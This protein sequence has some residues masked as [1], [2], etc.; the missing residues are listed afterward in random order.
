MAKQAP[1]GGIVELP[2]G[3]RVQQPLLFT[4]PRPGRGERDPL[5]PPP[6][7][8]FPGE[9]TPESSLAL[10]VSWFQEEMERRQYAAHTQTNYRKGMRQLL[11]FLSP[12]R[13]LREISVND[14]ERFAAWVGRQRRAAKTRELW[15]TAVRTFFGALTDAAVLN[16]NPA[17]GV[18][19][20]KAQSAPPRTLFAG[21]V[22]ALRRAASQALTQD[23]TMDTLPALLL[24]LILDAGL[25]LGEVERLG[26]DD[27][28]LSDPLRP[29][30]RIRYEDRRHRAKRRR[31]V[32]PPELT[33]L[34]QSYLEH[35]PPLA[36][37]TALLSCSRR[38]LQ[39]TIQHLGEAAGLKE[40]L[41]ANTLRWTHTARE[42]RS[43][44]SPDQMR[45]RL[46]LSEL[47]WR[48]VEA[49]LAQMGGR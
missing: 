9:L 19:A 26:I 14:L 15:I 4:P 28:D 49:K 25:R 34:I 13:R 46:G 45:A 39:Y 11:E 6:I 33:H 38:H 30:I 44:A 42:W 21:Q 23:G 17:Q 40:K 18:F 12:S 10:A 29:A 24:S 32:A 7:A 3:T 8:E 37:Q 36:G 35:N 1:D 22:D 2:D 20:H 43:G 27:V 31:V 48:D 16:Q 47:G 5:Q 41:T